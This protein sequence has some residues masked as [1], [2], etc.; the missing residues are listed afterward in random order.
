MSDKIRE[1]FDAWRS[2]NGWQRPDDPGEWEAWQAALS[3]QPTDAM[4]D[5][6]RRRGLSIDGDNAYKRDLI[7]CIIGAL[8]C[9]KQNTNPPP[10]GH[11]AQQFWEIGRAEG[12]IQEGYSTH[13]AP[14]PAPAAQDS[15]TVRR[16]CEI[17]KIGSEART[18]ACI[19]TNVENTK[20]FSDLLHAIEREFFM[21]PGEPDDN[22]PDDEPQPECLLNCW[23]STTEQYVEQF[24]AALQRIAPPAADQPDTVPVPQELAERLVSWL[25]WS[26]GLPVVAGQYMAK[27]LSE[28]RALLGKESV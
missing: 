17:F 18:Q 1:A 22:Y 21:V 26:G 24:R 15:E 5:E 19:L 25:D 16:I 2:S 11:W 10:A 13:S 9:G 12:E 14:A 6:M 3:Q 23:G 4:F 7:D 27:D 20:R 28:L 8:V